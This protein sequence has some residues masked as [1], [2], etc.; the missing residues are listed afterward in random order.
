MEEKTEGW[1]KTT[2]AYCGVGCGVEARPLSSGKLE[3]RGDAT[4]PANY[5]KL[6]TKGIALGETLGYEGR[7]LYPQIRSEGVWKKRDWDTALQH[8]ADRMMAIIEKYGP[9]AVAFYVSRQ[10]LTEDY[11]VANKLM[12]GFI[13]SSNIDSN[14]RLCMAS[15]VA[16]HKRAFGA[17]LVPVCYEDIELAD[18]VVLVGS[19]LAWCHPVLFQRLRL[20][21]QERPEMFIVVVDPRETETS[22]IADLHLNLTPGSDVA[23]FNGLLDY[24]SKHEGLDSAY[25]DAYTQGFSKAL[26]EAEKQGV[27][28][29]VTGLSTE[30]LTDFYQN[31]IDK[32]KVLSIYSQG[33]NQ[34]EQ[35]TDKVNS[36]INC[37][38]ASGKIG[39]SGCGPFSVTGQPNAMGGREVGALANMLAAHMELDNQEHRA[40]VSQYWQ[41]ETLAERPG[42]K[43]VELF[44][45]VLRGE[46]KAVWIMAT[47]P[48]VSLPDSNKISQALEKCP[49]VVVSDCFAETETANYADVLLP[50]QGWSEKS[51]TVTNSERRISRQRKLVA[52]PGEAKP[53]WWIVSHV[54]KKMGYS[55][56]FNFQ[57]EGQIFAEHA[58]LTAFG[59]DDGSR[60]FNLA[61]LSQLDAES[62]AQMG[63]QQWPITQLATNISQ[64]RLLTNHRYFT[65]SGK[66]HFIPVTQ[67]TK[68]DESGREGNFVLNTGRCRDQWHTMTRTGRAVS[69][70]KHIPEPFILIH[71]TSA[72]EYQLEEGS[73][74]QVSNDK[75]EAI[76]RVST[77]E[78]IARGQIF[79]PI[80]WSDTNSQS[81]KPCRVI[82]GDV[83]PISGQPAFKSASVNLTPL[84]SESS[85][86]VMSR[87]E[88]QLTGHIYWCR[89]PVE[90]GFLYRIES[91]QPVEKLVMQLR[92]DNESSVTGTT[93]FSAVTDSD[94]R[95]A[96]VDGERCLWMILARQSVMFNQQTIDIWLQVFNQ[97]CDTEWQRTFFC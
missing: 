48:V 88:L 46:V 52:A 24:L 41:T 54:A 42:L 90:N 32:K 16:G 49:L 62:Y 67:Q 58:G 64:R 17:D 39:K 73:L 23:L 60:A 37:H 13:G 68:S 15:A 89:Q 56:A 50:A 82:G 47:N 70:S 2:C 53:D 77:S 94:V 57:H 63:P 40:L 31:F 74:A 38:L 5:G 27:L 66:A 81:S 84:V 12:K 55:A 87:T 65:S 51:G 95:A 28:S 10:L 45:A 91:G 44:D 86:L 97:T 33:V 79:M 30:Q 78:E 36:I 71:P 19:N 25:I 75:G 29:S 61:G 3:V 7:L 6:C 22:S 14:S 26:G 1:I 34:S 83:D 69:L 85:A 8:V 35:G 9:D 96:A 20:A 4:H 76:A 92:G 59:N 11:Y 93:S 72:N 80:H 43:A 21:K 18:M